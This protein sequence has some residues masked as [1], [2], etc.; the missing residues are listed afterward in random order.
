MNVKAMGVLEIC[1]GIV[2]LFAC[3]K[4]EHVEGR[5]IEGNKSGQIIINETKFVILTSNAFYSCK[6]EA[7]CRSH[8]SND[9]RLVADCSNL[10]ND[11]VLGIHHDNAVFQMTGNRM[12]RISTDMSYRISLEYLELSLSQI[13]TIKPNQTYQTGLLRTYLESSDMDCSCEEYESLKWF[14]EDNKSTTMDLLHAYR[15]IFS[16]KTEMLFSSFDKSKMETRKPCD[17]NNITISM[18]VPV[19]MFFIS[20]VTS[21]IVYRYRWKLRYLFY[22][23]RAKYRRHTRITNAEDDDDYTYDAFIL[24]C[25]EN[26]QFVRKEVLSQLEDSSGLQLCVNVRDFIIGLSLAQ[27]ITNAVKK[28]RKIVVLL[29]R[30]YLD[31]CECMIEFT[32]A[33]MESIY[34]RGDDSVLFLVFYE[35]ISDKDL[36]LQMLGLIECKSYM[37]YPHNDA[38]GKVAFWDQLATSISK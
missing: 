6:E 24:Y 28:S 4:G 17:N 11:Y 3:F 16:N 35:D 34:A 32:M 38:Q 10:N 22:K 27:N 26:H 19:I 8:R 1:S 36:P 37:E 33:R 2:L 25:S 7:M 9:T 29:S 31:S 20:L 30:S 23:A 5:F 14:D 12:S 18:S 13:N 21:C 15:C